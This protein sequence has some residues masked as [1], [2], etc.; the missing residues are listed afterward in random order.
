MSDNPVISPLLMDRSEPIGNSPDG[1]GRRA[2]HVKATNVLVT[3]PYDEI[4]AT[5]PDA[6]TEVYTY[7]MSGST[8]ATV[9]V[10]YTDLT[11]NLLLSVTKS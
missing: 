7:K 8:V 5:Y 11:K 10:V 9:T 6:V 2:L 4:A 3:E 1:G